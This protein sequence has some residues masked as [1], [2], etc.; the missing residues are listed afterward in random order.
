MNITAVCSA[1][2]A[3][4]L[5]PQEDFLWCINVVNTLGMC[6]LC[7]MGVVAVWITMRLRSTT[8]ARGKQ[9][10]PETPPGAMRDKSSDV[11]AAGP[12]EDGLRRR[13]PSAGV[14]HVG[15]GSVLPQPPSKA[16]G[17]LLGRAHVL[18]EPRA[19]ALG[20]NATATIHQGDVH[21]VH[22]HG[23]DG[24]VSKHQLDVFDRLGAS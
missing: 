1:Y 9:V 12:D 21:H 17:G 8:K 24:E 4:S 15:N 2:V 20:D 7:I 13:Y 14:R 16:G 18:Q 11:A 22:H 19:F 6:T 10:A 3:R 5:T 23:L